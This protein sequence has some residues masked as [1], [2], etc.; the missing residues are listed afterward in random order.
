MPTLKTYNVFISHAWQDNKDYYNLEDKLDDAPYFRW[1]N[2]SKLD[3]DPLL[4]PKDPHDKKFLFKELEKQIRPVHCVLIISEMYDRQREWIQKEIDIAK[5][6]GKPIIGIKSRGMNGIP[7]AVQDAALE[8]VEMW[9]SESIIDAI[10]SSLIKKKKL[11][12]QRLILSM[13]GSL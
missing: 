1:V 9:D 5:S 11:P 12:N 3:N 2:F 13:R 4:H 10:M 8:I 6:F 7:K